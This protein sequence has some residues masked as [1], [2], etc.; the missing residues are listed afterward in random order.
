MDEHL[1]RLEN[2][3][4]TNIRDA[5]ELGCRAMERALNLDDPSVPATASKL[6]LEC[7]GGGVS[8]SFKSSSLGSHNPGR[9]LNALLSAEDAACISVD[10]R[11]IERLTEA[12]FYSQSGPVALPMRPME[13]GGTPISFPIHDCREAMHA[14]FVLVRYRG[15][16]V[17]RELA[18]RFI[19]DVLTYWTPEQRWDWRRLEREHGVTVRTGMPF[20]VAEARMIGPLVK[21]YRATGYGPSLELA[22]LFT[23]KVVDE[24]FLESGSYDA[25]T[26]GRRDNA[27]ID[28]EYV[29]QHGWH[30]HS[31]TCTLSSLAQLADLTGDVTLLERVQAF[32][33]NG[34][35]EIRDELGWV[36]E[37]LSPNKPNT[38]EG[39]TNNTGDVVETALILG[40]RGWSHCFHDAERILRGHFLPSQLR[41]LSFVTEI[42]DPDTISRS[43]RSSGPDRLNRYLGLFGF[44]ASYGIFPVG[45]DSTCYNHDVVGGSVGSLCEVLREIVRQDN[46]GHWVNLL[47]DHETESVR[48]E[49]PYT[50]DVLRVTVKQPRP[51]F[52]R[53]PP[54]VDHERLRVGTADEPR[55]LTNNYLFFARPPIGEPIP[56][57]FPLLP[58]Q[59]VLKHRRHPIR[60]RLV[61]DEVVQMDNFG[62]SL[63]FFDPYED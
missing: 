30:S 13:P 3:N 33:D 40:R 5:I 23:E 27:N 43:P 34:L 61:G 8:A 56:I 21:Y 55:R 39:E 14:L 60:V 11:V 41:K 47:F 58:Q 15:S 28:C 32:Y 18:E 35:W 2:V 62:Q 1:S 6:T 20:I 25:E 24:Y 7:L 51:L 49:S 50:H 12:A 17:A 37:R 36:V 4:T 52:L 22:L 46:A 38:D 48:V 16:T 44:P 57:E 9:H 29:M 63:T 26:F 42:A 59:L 31:I 54:W 10:E 53:L 45:K 19:G